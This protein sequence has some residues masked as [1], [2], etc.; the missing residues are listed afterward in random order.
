YD[1]IGHTHFAAPAPAAIYPRSLHD[2]LPIYR[3]PSRRMAAVMIA[4]AMVIAI[5]AR[6]WPLDR[7][8]IIAELA[9]LVIA[10]IVVERP[11]SRGDGDRKSTRLNSSH[12]VISYAVFCLKKKKMNP[13]FNTY[14]MYTY[15]SRSPGSS[16]STNFISATSALFSTLRPHSSSTSIIPCPAVDVLPAV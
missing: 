15:F 1:S 2:A 10:A 14:L 6:H 9:P 3:W 16:S 11:V 4:L 8:R 12:L 7:P 5:A 13:Y